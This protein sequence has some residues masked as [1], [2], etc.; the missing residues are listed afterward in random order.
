MNFRAWLISNL[1]VILSNMQVL[2]TF[3]SI[4][5]E[6]EL[7]LTSTQ[8]ALANSIYTWIFAVFQLFSGTTFSI[9]SSRKVYFFSIIAIILGFILLINSA[10][11]ISIILSQVLLAVGASFGFVGAAYFSSICFPIKKFGLIFSFVQTISSL[12]A[13]GS[14]ILFIT[15]ISMKIYWKHLI[16]GV[17]I[18]GIF[19]LALVFFCLNMSEFKEEKHN[20]LYDTLVA[21]I[22]SILMV[23]R[24][25]DIWITSVVGAATFGTFL[26]LNTLWGPRLL[27]DHGF[28]SMQSGVAT[29]ILWFGL[30]VGAPVTDQISRLF[31]NRR[32]VISIFAVIQGIS[33]IILIYSKTIIAAYICMFIFG[34]ASGGHMLNFTVGSDLVRREYI[35]TT[36]SIIN[37]IMFVGSGIIVYILALLSKNHKHAFFIIFVILITAAALNY[38]TKEIYTKQGT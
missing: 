35:S 23:L 29:A 28:N 37:G 5:L 3:I 10:S 13:F 21:I 7:H 18:Y 19:T 11:F 15:L 25:R 30:A 33:I 36:S 31:K 24:I 9:I 6:K 12:A 14:Q 38:L 4:P 34:F 26:A 2:Y 16:I 22:D 20:K 27:S 32:D 17:I 1:V 8:I